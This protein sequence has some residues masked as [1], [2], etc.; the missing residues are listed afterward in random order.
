MCPAARLYEPASD[1]TQQRAPYEQA[2]GP[3]LH[4]FG[5]HHASQ[6]HRGEEGDGQVK[7][8][9]GGAL[10]VL[11]RRR[12]E[13]WHDLLGAQLERGDNVLLGQ[14]AE[15]AGHQH[16]VAEAELVA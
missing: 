5:P 4:P 15:E 13:A 12:L 9:T 1:D 7:A 11:D 8:S 16:E 10:A 2:A 14:V 6:D 3:A